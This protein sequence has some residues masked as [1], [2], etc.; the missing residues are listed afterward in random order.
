MNLGGVTIIYAGLSAGA[1]QQPY[2]GQLYAS[3]GWGSYM[4]S[5]SGSLPPGLSVSSSGAISG[6]PTTSGWYA[7]QVKVTDAVGGTASQDFT[8]AIGGPVV[9]AVP[10]NGPY[11]PI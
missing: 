8:I 11:A 10:P 4:W 1:V 2:S 3:G 5:S 6:T 9:T 7:F